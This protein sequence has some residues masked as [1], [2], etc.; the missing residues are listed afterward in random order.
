MDEFQWLEDEEEVNLHN[1]GRRYGS[2]GAIFAEKRET[3]FER[4]LLT[5]RKESGIL[6]GTT[7]LLV[8]SN[9]ILM[10]M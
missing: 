8:V 6:L 9:E 2:K 3:I 1:L 5:F 10:M 4:A 7:E